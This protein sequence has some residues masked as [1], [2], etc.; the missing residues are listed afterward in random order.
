MQKIFNHV[1][2][3][4]HIESLSEMKSNTRGDGTRTYSTPVGEYP[5]VTTVVGWEKQKFFAEWR[6]NNPAESKRVTRRGNNLHN[7]IEDYLNNE[8]IELMSVD[9][10]VAD[11]FM[12]IRPELDKI[13]NIR[14]L[15]VPL[16]SR[17]LELAGR[18]DCI[19]EYN[20]TLSVIDF[21]GSTRTKRSKD[22]ENYHMQA[23]AYCIMWQE[24]TGEA[25]KEYNILVASE[26]RTTPQVFTG[27]PIDYVSNL[28]KA[29][30]NYQ[31][32]HVTT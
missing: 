16:F 2:M 13:D 3:P 20:G 32:E 17:T 19:A 8:D 21:K 15:E 28:R 29:I 24:R 23:T 9:P 22:I 6:R 4:D 14:A 31:R 25:I 12:Q 5:S 1:E 27:R 7:L 10:N 18:V 11:L 30:L 26:D